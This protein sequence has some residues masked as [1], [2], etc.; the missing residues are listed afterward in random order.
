MNNY[1]LEET[2]IGISNVPIWEKFFLRVSRNYDQKTTRETFTESSR[3]KYS[4]SCP[5]GSRPYS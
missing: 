5:N 3:K 4:T 2:S 1:Y